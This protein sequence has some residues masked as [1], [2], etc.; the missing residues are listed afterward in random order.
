MQLFFN[1]TLAYRAIRTNRLRSVLTIVIIALGITALVGI[2]TSI[3]VMKAG[4][5][6]SVV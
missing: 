1:L 6:K 4:D 3:E 2:L 5:R